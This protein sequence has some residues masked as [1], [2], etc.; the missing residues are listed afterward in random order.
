[1]PDLRDAGPAYLID[2]RRPRCPALGPSAFWETLSARTTPPGV[3]PYHGGLNRIL[4]GGGPR[5]MTSKSFRMGAPQIL[6]R[7][8]AE[9]ASSTNLYGSKIHRGSPELASVI[10]DIRVR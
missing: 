4:V 7:W 5:S 8:K 6:S 10:G 9:P 1:M 2:S 3:S